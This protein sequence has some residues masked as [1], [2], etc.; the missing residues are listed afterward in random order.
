[1]VLHAN[2]QTGGSHLAGCASQPGNV[3]PYTGLFPKGYKVQVAAT[4][5]NPAVF[6]DKTVALVSSQN[7]ET[8]TK[9][10]RDAY[11]RGGQQ[12]AANTQAMMA[13]M[14]RASGNQ[15]AAYGI[16]LSQ[17]IGSDM[18]SG[19][20]L[21]D[22]RRIS[23]EVVIGLKRSFKEVL[24]ATDFASA[25]DQHAQFIALID[26]QQPIG[27]GVLT[28]NSTM[29][30]T[31]YVLDAKLNQILTIEHVTKSGTGFMGF[32][33]MDA[34]GA[35]MTTTVEGLRKALVEKLPRVNR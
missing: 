14:A 8:Q 32:D 30:A 33:V 10:W 11:E 25:L 7:F 22:P 20:K 29:T 4:P 13:D 18:A 34:I 17:S 9:T 15:A 16:G 26:F 1:M 6:R 23:D 31:V 27:I 5:T 21:T 3:G 28:D 2:G 24:V 35:G 12:A 19:R